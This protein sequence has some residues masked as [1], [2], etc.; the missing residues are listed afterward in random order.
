MPAHQESAVEK[1]KQAGAIKQLIDIRT[2]KYDEYYQKNWHGFREVTLYF[3]LGLS[4]VGILLVFTVSLVDIVAS[5]LGKE[6]VKGG[7]GM[8]G[9]FFMIAGMLIT[10]LS[11][12]F[13]NK[14]APYEKT[15]LL[16]GKI[17]Q[18]IMAY[19]KLIAELKTSHAVN[20][21]VNDEHCA[22]ASAL[23][24][25]NLEKLEKNA[26]FL[27]ALAALLL[28]EYKAGL[29]NNDAEVTGESQVTIEI[30]KALV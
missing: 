21:L 12:Y 28:A 23:V 29:Y 4:G 26:D 15:R 11:N 25:S 24:D 7:P 1:L 3:G 8:Y 16:F 10:W 2:D 13:E 18:I 19:D 14:Q 6:L 27:I 9:F 22:P 20:R 30:I 17:E 5:A